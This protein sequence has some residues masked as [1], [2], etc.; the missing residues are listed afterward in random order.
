MKTNTRRIFVLA[1]VISSIF[2]SCRDSKQ[3]SD[4]LHKV[5]VKLPWSISPEFAFLYCDAA[6]SSRDSSINLNFEPSK[7]SHEV[8]QAFSLKKTDFGFLSGDSLIVARQKGIRIKALF[9]LYQHSPAV[10]VAMKGSGISKP[11]DLLGKKVG[12]IKASSTY[13]QFIG[14]MKN[15]N[16]PLIYEGNNKNIILEDAVNGGVLQLK[17]GQ[18]DA[19]TS[20]ANFAPVQLSAGGD[21]IETPIMFKDYGI[22]IYGTVFAASEE[23]INDNPQLVRDVTKLMLSRVREM[24]SNPEYAAKQ[25][26]ERSETVKSDPLLIGQTIKATI[27]LIQPSGK[28]EEIG[29]MSSAQWV[30]TLETLVETG[31]AEEL[32]VSSCYQTG[33]ANF[34]E[35]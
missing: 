15:A 8:A 35:N 32:D 3:N 30:K 24:V 23:M 31:Q 29:M 17:T 25:F 18:I 6:E 28:S 5:T 10:V 33:F 34:E 14:M 4:L 16:C 2:P 9:A 7:G 11:A 1:L 21:Q 27:D 19:L 13:P 26:Q 12:V 20:F 22:D